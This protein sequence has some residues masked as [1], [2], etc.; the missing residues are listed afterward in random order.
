MVTTRTKNALQCGDFT[1]AWKEW[2]SHADAHKTWPNWKNDWTQAFNK[3]RSIQCLTGSIFHANAN[4]E[5][6]LSKKMVPSLN[7]LANAAVQKNHTIEKLV[8]AGNN[9]QPPSPKWRASFFIEAFG[10]PPFLMLFP[11]IPDNHL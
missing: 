7:N 3:N 10:G 1:E 4:I 5:D 2:N 9:S 11:K 8:A 6:E